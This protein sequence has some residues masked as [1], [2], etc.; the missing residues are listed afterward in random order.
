M[1]S[2]IHSI[3]QKVD[4]FF[5]QNAKKFAFWQIY[6]VVLQALLTHSHN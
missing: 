4:S 3:G 1:L 6:R 5:D 2:S